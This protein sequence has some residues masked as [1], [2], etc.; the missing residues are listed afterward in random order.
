MDKVKLNNILTE[1]ITKLFET[2]L[3]YV[4]VA[5]PSDRYPAV[6]SRILRAGNNCLRN[7]RVELDLDLETKRNYSL[8][9][10]E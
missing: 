3:D 5:V 10:G 4:Q 6:R 2:T 8:V 7:L 9:R 1:Q